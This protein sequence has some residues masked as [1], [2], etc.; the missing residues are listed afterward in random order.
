MQQANGQKISASSQFNPAKQLGPGKRCLDKDSIF[1]AEEYS[2]SYFSN[3]GRKEPVPL[4]LPKRQSPAIAT[5]LTQAVEGHETSSQAVLTEASA[6][7]MLQTA[8][9][10]KTTQI[11]HALAQVPKNAKGT[12]PLRRC[13][14][15]VYP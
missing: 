15:T 6:V 4:C 7:E 14:P 2:A 12:Y 1:T 5:E 8:S 11:Q 13:L 10:A 3:F 9:K